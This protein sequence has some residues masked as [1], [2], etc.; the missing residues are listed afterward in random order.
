MQ[1]VAPEPT[2]S[3][4]PRAAAPAWQLRLLG[5]VEARRGDQVV[6]RWPSRPAALLLARL[7]L[8]PQR[9]H[10]REE[11]VELLWPGVSLDVGRNRLRQ[12]LSTLKSLLEAGATGPVI[13]ADR[14]CLRLASGS[15]QSDA[16]EFERLVRARDATGARQLDR[17][18]L[19]PG[20]YDEWVLEARAHFT[21]LHEKLESMPRAAPLARAPAVERPLPASWTRVF[22]IEQ[23]AT[24]L[25]TLMRHERLVSVVGPGGCGKTRLALEVARSL[26]EPPAWAPANEWAAGPTRV[27]FVPL[28]DCTDEP[29]VLA[30]LAQTLQTTGIDLLVQV[31][32]TL[33]ELPTLL[34][35]DNF[36]QLVGSAQGLL[37]RLLEGAPALRLLVTSRLKLGLPG[38][39]VFMLRGLALPDLTPPFKP[40]ALL[41][42][43]AVALFVDRARAARAD[44][45]PDA[46]QLPGIC[47][48]VHWL[49]GMPLAVELAASRVSSFT[50]ARMLQLLSGPG[51][52]QARLHLLS[53]G[54][55]RAGHDPRHASMADVIQWSWQLLSPPDQRLLAALGA[56]G[57]ESSVPALAALLGATEPE[58]AVRLDDLGSHSMLQP[59]SG[60][61]HE[62]R[63]VM[64]EPVREFVRHQWPAEEWLR[65][66]QAE[67]QW[68]LQWARALGPQ[69]ATPRAAAEARSVR[70]ALGNAALDPAARWRLALALWPVWE[71]AGMPAALQAALEQALRRLPA[72]AC[73]AA[74]AGSLAS[75][76]HELLCQLRHAAGFVADAQAHAEAALQFAGDDA[77][78]RSRALTRR[79][80]VEL[81]G[82][83]ADVDPGPPAQRLDAWLQQ[84]VALALDAGDREAQARALNER[85]RMVSQL[86]GDWAG[87]EALLAQAQALWLELGNRSMA[88]GR[89][90]NRARCWSRLGRQ[91]EAMAFF[92]LYERQCAEDGNPAG[93]VD[94]L[95]S[96]STLWAQQRRWADALAV[97]RRCVQLCWQH[98]NRSGLAYGLWNLAQSL[99]HGDRPAD[100]LRLT[101]FA[102]THW[103]RQ[104]GALSPAERRS[105]EGV[106]RLARLKL[107]AGRTEALW[108]EGQGL[109]VAAAVALALDA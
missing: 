80:W 2:R 16:V 5:A 19:M 37:L 101:A 89:L 6:T 78:L 98:W 72:S 7:A 87:A 79:V 47:D 64:L 52:G 85:A 106:R 13:E 45:Q 18:E 22:G 109:G 48:L 40:E 102:A 32:Q 26:R 54:G 68:L 100:A 11:M 14:Q 57:G 51:D 3:T 92:E 59:A 94:G 82:L 93:Q 88:A 39:Q 46:A 73:T 63:F 108:D 105:V 8:A 58:V 12:T 65:F 107:G 99:A 103:E 49:D 81:V 56:C 84:A 1:P 61:D 62:P 97:D 15:L 38:E 10:P 83:P 95:L 4:P 30:A 75:R 17:G 86:R 91:A 104:F 74:E 90:Y 29:Q 21:A 25:L 71:R 23:R 42:N 34:V 70:A 43:P 9:A 55:P 77:S 67:L 41:L 35:L 53:R 33:C 50:P 36:E 44:F 66:Q 27:V 31:Q 24:R 28:V 76:G 69:L 60:P 96:M 20:H